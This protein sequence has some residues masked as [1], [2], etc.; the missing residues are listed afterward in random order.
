MNKLY[1]TSTNFT[2][3][4]YKETA[5][6]V[7]AFYDIRIF[8][9][10]KKQ[11]SILLLTCLLIFSGKSFA[12]YT[13]TGTF[14]QIT[15]LA[16]LTDG[17]YV[18]AYGTT[19]AM[20]N[21]SSSSYFGNTSISPSS[22]VITNPATTIVWRI[23]T[24]GS[25]RIIYN[26]AG[27]VYAGYYGTGN[28]A[29]GV[30]TLNDSARWTFAYSTLFTITNIKAPTRLLQYNTSSPRFA[31]YTGS[32]QNITLYKA[33]TFY[34]TY[35]G[36]S[37]TGGTAPTKQAYITSST[38]TVASNTGSLVRTGYIFNGWNTAA[39][40]SGT[41]YNA[42]SGTFTISANT[43]LYAEWTPAGNTVTFD[44]NGGTGTMANQTAS[45]A[46]NLTANAFTRTGYTF[47]GWAT[48]SGG[49][50]A[51]TNG[52]SYP[53]S[54]NATL[55]AVW[56]PNNNTI[57]F[58]ANGGTGTMANQTIATAASAALTTNSFTRSGFVFDGWATSSGGAV[59]YTDGATYTMGTA[60]VT[61]YAH[62]TA[63]GSYTVIF[64]ANGGT[65]TMANQTASSP[66]ALT[67]NAFT[68]IGYIFAGW[69]TIAGGGGT[70]YANGATY[71]FTTNVTLYAQWTATYTLTYSGNSN[72]SGTAPT[73]ASSPYVSGTTVTVKANTGTLAR[74]GYTFAGWN[75]NSA[76]SGTDYAAT[77]SVTFSMPAA[78]T[79]LYAKWTPNNN[80]I[81][82]DGN[83]ATGGSM[84]N[85]TLATAAT[86]SLTTNAYT[87]TGYTFAGWA[88]TA[89]GAVAYADGA[90][91]TMGTTNVTLYAKWTPN[92]Y[93]IT[94]DA[95]GGSG[96]MANQTIA[97][98]AT[99]ALTANAFTRAGYV[100]DGW[101]TTAGGA[102]AYADGDSYT[103][104]TSNV[105][106]YAQWSVYVGPWEDFEAGTKSSYTAANV[107][108]T[109]GSWNL[110]DALL[111][112]SA[113]DRKNGSQSVRMT[114]TGIVSMNFDIITG[115]AT[116]DILHAK[117]GSD[118]NSTWR[119]EAST[120]GGSTWTAYVS[121]TITTS[122]TTLTNQS[123]TLNL[124]G[125]VRFRIVKLSGSGI[126]LN[127]DDI[128]YTPFASCTPPTTSATALTFSNPTTNSLDL[129]FTRGNGD[130]VL[131]IAKSGSA[132]TDPTAGTPYNLG[133]AVGGGTVV[134]KGIASG[135]T[136][137]TT[138]TIGSLSAET[139]YYFNIYEYKSSGGCYQATP[140]SGSSYTLST[141][142]TAHPT[143]G[144]SATTCTTTSIDVTVPA[145]S[146]GA[147]GYLVIYKSGS[148][149][150]GLPTD[151]QAYINGATF[152]DATV[153]ATV[154]SASTVTIAGLSAG[155]NY[156]FQLIPYNANSTPSAQTYNYRT[157]GSI[158]ATNFTTLTTAA[159]TAS[160]VNTD[161][162]YTYT[163]NID[164]ASYQSTPV[165][166]SAS[167][168]VGVH[169]FIIQDG[170]GVSNDAD[171][172]PTLLKGITYS[173]TGTANTV[174]SAA[175]FTTTGTRIRVATSIGANTIMFSNLPD[176]VTLKTPTDN[177]SIQVILRVTFGTT[178]TDNEKLL[179]TVTG[180]TSGDV[181]L[182]SQFNGASGGGAISDN[183]VNDKNKI[184]VI[185]DRIRFTTQ[186]TD[187]S[188][189]TN[190]AT[191][192][193]KAVDINANIDADA[194]KSVV[195]T[196]SGT[197]MTSGSPY[198]LSGGTLN[199]S[200]VQF[201][202]AQ[203]PITLTATTTGYTD[204]DDVSST[205]NITTVAVGTYRTTSSG[206]WPAG[207]A[208]WERYNGSSWP[209]ATPVAAATD[210]LIIRHAITSR[211]SFAAPSPSYTSMVV[212]SGGTFTDGHNSTFGMLQ[213]NKDGK[214]IVS[215]PGVVINSAGTVTV[216]S[217]GTLVINSATLNH[218]DGF[219]EGT[220]NFKRK[221]TVEVQQFDNNSSPGEDDLVDSD[222]PI[223]PNA[224]GYYFGNLYIN[225]TNSETKALTLVGI[226]G[227]QK[228]CE[229]DLTV[230]NQTSGQMVQLT[231]V[232]ANVEIGGNVL[233]TKNKF[234]FGALTSANAVHTVNGN[235]TVNGATAVIDINAT[236][237]SSGTVVV[238]L[239]GDLIGIAGTL[240]CTDASDAP[241]SS[242]HFVNP[243]DS[244]NVDVVSTVTLNRF[245]M[246]VDSSANVK[247][248]N[249]NLTLNNTSSFTVRSR[250]SFNFN[251]TS[252][253]TP[254]L[255][256][257][258]A[259][260][261]GTN[262]FT[263]QTRGTL[264]ITSP[265][266]IIKNTAT[267]GAA[268]GNV[269]NISTSNRDYNQTATYWY[270]SKANQT[271][272]DGINQTLAS[273]GFGKVV[274]CDLPT[275]S[276][277]LTPTVSFALT[278]NTDISTT[279]GKLDVRG[280]QFLETTT[281]YI[282]GT[283]GTLY[284]SP[285]TL[286]RILKGNTSVTA[287]DADQIPRMS[288]GTYPY[289]LTG[290]TIELAGTGSSHAFQTVRSTFGGR[291]YYQYLKFSGANTFNTD[292]K[293]LSSQ[294]GVDS[295]LIIT[296]TTVVD[297]RTLSNAAASFVGNGGLVMDGG[298]LRI[299]KLSDPNPE[300]V[301]DNVAYNITGG[302][303]EFYGTSAT[304]QQQ[305]RGNY[306]SLVTKPKITYN[307]I[308]V[309]AIAANWSTTSTFGDAGN[310]DM[311]SSF[312]VAGT[313][314]VFAPAT[315]R[316]DD[317]D[318]VGGA[319]QVDVK[320]YAGLLYGNQ[321]GLTTGTGTTSGNIR[322]SGADIL[323]SNASYG[324][325]GPNDQVTG[326]SLPATTKGL[327]IYKS[328]G[329]RKVTLTNTLRA[330]SILKM[331]SGHIITGTT[332]I[333]EL[334]V[335]TS[336]KG[337]LDYTAGYVVG[338]MRRWYNGTNSGI[339]SGLFPLGED[340]SGT[341]RN[342]KYLIEYTSGASAGG[343][344]DVNF[345]HVDMGL[346][347][348]PIA[349]I[350]AAG[351]CATFDVTT[352][353]DEGYW[354]GTPQ[355]STLSDGSYTLALTGENFSTVTDLCQLTLLKRVGAGSWTTPGTH[356]QPTGSV[357][358]PT[359]SRSGIS[360]FSN[361][362][363]GGG[364]PNPLPVELT[365]FTGTCLDNGLSQIMWST[366][367]ELNS[368]HF[369]LQRSADG[370]HYTTVAVVQA[371][372]FSNQPKNYTV[373]DSAAEGNSNYYRLTEV[374]GDNTATNYSFIV[375]ECKEVDGTNIYYSEPKITVEINSNTNKQIV[376]NVYEVS[377]KLLHQESKQLQRGYN[378]FNLGL[379]KKLANGVYVIQ[380]VDGNKISSSKLMVH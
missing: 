131:I 352:T 164:Y 220:E 245:N 89:G 90:S 124:T 373:I 247:L 153:G 339:A 104:G 344:L 376:L 96:T 279:G 115:V 8:N 320:D 178:V 202:A 179:F 215:I 141:E 211:A 338:K 121:S 315:F 300:L 280:G 296:G 24:N 310:V 70:A 78:N 224:A 52:A 112:T 293:N 18:V 171:A 334:G 200:D 196:T 30:S 166:I 64:D 255:V 149:P 357:A 189:N 204:N 285:G 207:T 12:A 133:D 43:T 161:A 99:V 191:F 264:K 169:N 229:N 46:T 9:F 343:Y 108:C 329:A 262:T 173:Y 162:T 360:G 34:V 73:D 60:N 231:N 102:I 234:S 356:L 158:L 210:L 340:I 113:S 337:T 252:G 82:F 206:T 311:N 377:G 227:T 107:T 265:N 342:R 143:T 68:R 222:N 101:S 4:F 38:V 87:R 321:Y 248:L 267:Y 368:D 369:I 251:W 290:G 292:F 160:L 84:G 327:Y 273:T 11:L 65:G 287:S 180:V 54:A 31:C 193:I 364:P 49:T 5:S 240:M 289:V 275:N 309:N 308:E 238:N 144:L 125:N 197:G 23:E 312:D 79:I 159:S 297:C 14:T 203:G 232:A 32:Q 74:T 374:A 39:D 132:A 254:L 186:P 142:P 216:D 27:S 114:N 380:M 157:I 328:T 92:N 172:L 150:T 44:A 147:D 349:G 277:T 341:L 195:L 259:S 188:T 286:Y 139:E 26:E 355:S 105:T 10:M 375:V 97:T 167:Q 53:F 137:A 366:A 219:F 316:M 95:N 36:N 6:Q 16:S 98:G 336:I 111:G 62:W 69:N 15:S 276:L 40:G 33:P 129:N 1:T 50:V 66:T 301:G 37:N 41:H 241:A 47:A 209:S 198:T 100:F 184:E 228:L 22:G 330:D 155:F 117:Y 3:Y 130:S 185:A 86:A 261:T 165:P 123:F 154:N 61:L 319:G 332:N 253:G 270:V 258:P 29:Y 187:Q 83:G 88:T 324:F 81:T 326:A 127:I 256:T 348:I 325:V 223:S 77:G 257:Q 371:A 322:T 363:F 299:K 183:A 244:Q 218:V 359:V 298:R 67:T 17:Y 145:P 205:F 51:Y 135:I 85:Q 181:C 35:N 291:P 302:T 243:I 317:Q 314:T 208:T 122:S 13:G 93:T 266:G 370:T 372:G 236:N 272:G 120:T 192:T 269:Q 28:N 365:S 151:G 110:N 333:L 303:V 221:S 134:Y 152:G 378:K 242:L 268:I 212:D 282:T 109:A 347:G 103:M 249:N 294:T 361:F 75:T 146:A 175:L 353:E 274:I 213:V 116:V 331:S 119:L 138:Q 21:T 136:T 354:I 379:E 55:Y 304:Q 239:K 351:S 306:T 156:Y 106:L 323:S 367:S 281:A 163:Q 358:V 250:G 226:I 7:L 345:N 2:K 91:Y 140:L 217:G 246:F 59:A 57:T 128:Y 313:L 118:A 199:I 190:L 346:A 235:I 318:F 263:L 260:P 72:T 230:E 350:P 271:T 76:G 176:T 20:N 214:F 174:R 288:G 284:M 177:S 362:G 58:D 305:I 45:S 283:D 48:T 170:N 126:R 201:N 148:L 94:F 19:Q 80:T 63:A 233:V 182:Y 168:S 25:G 295:A 307:D 225:Y 56:T 278:D 237:S 194:S 335:N 71:G 42:G